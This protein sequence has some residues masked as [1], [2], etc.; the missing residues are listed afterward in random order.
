[1]SYSLCLKCKKRVVW[2]DKYC[3]DCQ[4]EFGL[5]NLSD[6][7]KKNFVYEGFDNWAK[8]EV[9]KDLDKIEKEKQNK[10]KGGDTI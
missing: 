1:M 7:Q 5:P 6:W 3:R 10:T 2:Y 8:K 9:E 4:K